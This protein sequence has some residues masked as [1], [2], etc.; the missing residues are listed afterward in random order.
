M[1]GCVLRL[2]AVVEVCVLGV[3]E[4]VRARER[5]RQSDEGVCVSASETERRYIWGCSSDEGP[6]DY[7]QTISALTG[8]SPSSPSTL[9]LYPL[10]YLDGTLEN[11]I[12]TQHL[13]KTKVSGGRLEMTEHGA[14]AHSIPH[15]TSFAHV[16]RV[17]HWERPAM[18][19]QNTAKTHKQVCASMCTDGTGA[20]QHTDAFV[21]PEFVRFCPFLSLAG[22]GVQTHSTSPP[23]RQT[24]ASS[25]LS[26]EPR[27]KQKRRRAR[28]TVSE[29]EEVGADYA[30][31]E[32]AF[33]SC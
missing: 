22:Y 10:L 19:V 2:G 28:P 7:D 24:A 1:C 27:P 32:E 3:C 26:A 11:L 25:V 5:E 17:F 29:S 9:S 8:A 31:P 13:T 23:D 16:L 4:F 18:W 14:S 33:R 15:I 30:A 6:L 12:V 21:A 20:N